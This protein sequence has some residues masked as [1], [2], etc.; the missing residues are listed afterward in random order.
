MVMLSVRYENN[1]VICLIQANKRKRTKNL[2]FYVLFIIIIN[3]NNIV[4]IIIICRIFI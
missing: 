4:V 2:D 3:N 1:F